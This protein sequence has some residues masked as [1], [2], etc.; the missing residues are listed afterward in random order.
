MTGASSRLRG[1]STLSSGSTGGPRRLGEG[2]NAFRVPGLVVLVAIPFVINAVALLPELTIAP[3]PSTTISTTSSSSSRP[4]R[5]SNGGNVLDS[6]CRRSRR[7]AQ[8]LYYHTCRRS[9]SSPAAFAR[10]FDLL[11]VFDGVRYLLIVAPIHGLCRCDVRVLHSRG[12]ARC[13]GLDAALDDLQY[14][15]E[16]DDYVFRGLGLFTQLFA[17]HIAFL[18]VAVAYRAFQL[19]KGLWIDEVLLGIRVL[20][21][22]FYAYMTV[23]AIDVLF[24]WV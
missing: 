19:G 11:T 22:V 10:H 13:R 21:H 15:F 12:H 2:I 5:P 8:F 4:R 14:S 17:M 7:R 23:M 24:L 16:Y 1:H 20:T 18:T 9:W 3:H 6:G